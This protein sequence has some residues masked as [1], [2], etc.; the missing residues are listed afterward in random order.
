MIQ[1][2][3]IGCVLRYFIITTQVYMIYK[4]TKQVYFF[5]FRNILIL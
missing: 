1:V 4:Y 2:E 5:D 3:K